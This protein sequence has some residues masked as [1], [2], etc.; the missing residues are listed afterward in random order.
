MYIF[1][2]TSLSAQMP[3]FCTSKKPRGGPDGCM[4]QRRWFVHAEKGCKPYAYCESLLEQLDAKTGIN[5]FTSKES[6]QTNC[7]QRKLYILYYIIAKLYNT[8]C[9]QARLC[10]KHYCNIIFACLVR[11]KVV[12]SIQR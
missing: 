4:R 10:M 7:T 2:P 6:C 9:N 5:Y 3:S 12:G 11:V 1:P 8:A